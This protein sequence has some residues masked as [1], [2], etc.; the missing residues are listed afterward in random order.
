MSKFKT[1]PCYHSTHIN[2][3]LKHI[4]KNIGGPKNK[5]FK[6]DSFQKQAIWA[7]EQTDVIVSSPT[8]SGKTWIAE[9][10]INMAFRNGQKVWYACPLKALSNIKF[11]EFSQIYSLQ[12]VGILTGDRKE[13][14][15]GQ[16]I[17]GT[18]EILRNQLYD[19]MHRNKNINVNLV[20]LDEAH[21]LGD[22]ERGVV[23]EEII[24]YLPI[25][26]R[27]LLLSATVK[28]INQIARWLNYIRSK[29]CTTIYSNQ[30]PVPLKSIFI[31]PNGELS[32]LIT[33]HVIFP[34]VRHFLEETNRLQ[35]NQKYYFQYI[36]S[37][38]TILSALA[39]ANLL[40]AIFF[41]TSRVNCDNA[42]SCIASTYLNINQQ[43]NQILNAI[44]DKYIKNHPFLTIHPQLSYL[45]KLHIASHHAGQLP[46][47]R[48][49][50]EELMQKRLLKAI[51][52]TSTM[53]VGVNFPTRTVVVTQSD[54]FNGRILINLTATDLLQM[55]GRAGRRGIDKIGFCLAVP[56]PLNNIP[57]ITDLLNSSPEPI[58]SQLFINFSMILNLLLS[59][60]PVDIK[61]LLNQS[62]VTFQQ[63]DKSESWLRLKIHPK[64]IFQKSLQAL[65][66]LI[67]Q[68]LNNIRNHH[69]QQFKTI[70]YK[71][72]LK[73]K[74]KTI[75][76]NIQI[77]NNNKCPLIKF[78]SY[79][80]KNSVE[81]LRNNNTIIRETSKKY[82][83]CCDFIRYLKFLRIKGYVNIH[84]Q[85]TADGIWASN[86]RLDQPILVAEVIRRKALP[87]ND[88]I[89]LAALLSLFL[90]NRK[91]EIEIGY[92][93]QR[94]QN[95]FIKL[96]HTLAPILKHL[97][98][99]GFET[100]MLIKS[101]ANAIFAWG[102]G[103]EFGEV[104]FIYS[105]A[106][107]NLASL[108]Y[109][110]CDNLRQ[111]TALRKTHTKLAICASKAIDLLLKP[112]IFIPK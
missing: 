64:L 70:Y 34:K 51:F 18:T 16:L 77:N 60:H 58:K 88:P 50:V 36:L 67:Y 49:L 24:I 57:L 33:S 39:N 65:N 97:H 92:Q 59:Y 35:H 26:V 41:L 78:C 110:T 107:G 98:Q 5:S 81:F 87:Q 112:P 69:Y 79:N 68:N 96:Q 27:L 15:Y 4:L 12:Q 22:P 86:L 10:A 99:C 84:G 56:G 54:R 23:W 91:Q 55:T 30:R 63:L 72:K 42:L 102:M 29:L 106:E 40:P 93:N 52:S 95:A 80:T 11:T 66:N 38:S 44:I 101:A 108:I 111:I 45:R 82:I 8:G 19:S 47:W 105:I 74:K 31:F 17:I 46:L 3:K 7:L 71:N 75:N 61:Q 6:P 53:T 100:P 103:T 21:F 48:F 25:K 76:K 9:Q 85:L 2:S 32:P 43:Q 109:R 62:L 90:N 83:S 13:N 28:N 94:L 37:F 104:A 1:R 20:I 73:N 14:I 89:L